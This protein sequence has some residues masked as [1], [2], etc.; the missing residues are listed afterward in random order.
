MCNPAGGIDYFQNMIWPN[1]V[2]RN[3]DDTTC[4]RAMGCHAED[5]GNA[6]TFKTMPV[7]YEANFARVQVQLNCGTPEASPFLTKP[8][9]GVD[10]HG[11]GD[12]FP[13]E[14]DPAVQVFLDWFQ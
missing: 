1:Y 10:L 4:T 3:N 2:I 5:G 9:A 13:D 8:L 6:M 7:D 11:G 12:I 14:N